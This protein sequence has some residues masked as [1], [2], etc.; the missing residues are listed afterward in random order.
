MC[1]K[2]RVEHHDRFVVSALIREHHRATE[3]VRFAAATGKR[4]GECQEERWGER[5]VHFA[6]W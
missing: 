1:V 4:K 3:D 6:A 2:V 5:A